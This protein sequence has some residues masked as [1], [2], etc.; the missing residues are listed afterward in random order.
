M[1]L[2]CLS[3][4]VRTCVVRRQQLQCI[5]STGHSFHPILL[6][7]AQNVCLDNISDKLKIKKLGHEVKSK[8]NLVYT[9]EVTFSAKSRRNLL[10]TKG[11]FFDRFI[12]YTTADVKCLCSG[13]K[14]SPRTSI[15]SV[16]IFSVL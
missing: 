15:L 14:K 1:I 9:L 2:E 10:R 11:S 5:H 8:K 3:C 12:Y 6:K 4:V 13:F 7:L 16:V